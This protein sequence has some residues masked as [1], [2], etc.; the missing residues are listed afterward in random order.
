MCLALVYCDPH[1]ERAAWLSNVRRD[2]N[3]WLCNCR[4]WYACCHMIFN[5][6][7]DSNHWYRYCIRQS[8]NRARIPPE[9]LVKRIKLNHIISRSVPRLKCIQLWNGLAHIP[10]R[11]ISHFLLRRHD[12]L[13][14]ER[15]W[16]QRNNKKNKHK[17]VA[18]K[19]SRKFSNSEVM[20]RRRIP[21]TSITS[22]GVVY[23]CCSDSLRILN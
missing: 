10:N 22:V 12:H 5:A 16:F 7:G 13:K 3:V 18:E 14:T 4:L 17:I 23:C 9:E 21:S 20:P 2:E 15:K 6:F 1:W 11:Y 19:F 8:L